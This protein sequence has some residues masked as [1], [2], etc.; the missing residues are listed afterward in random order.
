MQEQK[1]A[2][3]PQSCTR[4]PPIVAFAMICIG[5]SGFMIILSVL[6]VFGA[7]SYV[8]IVDAFVENFKA[9]ISV[10]LTAAT[11]CVFAFGAS[12]HIGGGG[13]KQED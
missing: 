11:V 6:S 3:K 5:I 12:G 1:E 13:K 9:A 2:S 8:V 10:F 7:Y 4:I